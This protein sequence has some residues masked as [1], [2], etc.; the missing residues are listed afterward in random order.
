MSDIYFEYGSFK[1]PAGE[2]YPRRIEL[3]PQH[4]PQGFRWAS[5]YR[6]VV[7]GNFCSDIGTPLTPATVATRVSELEAAYVGDYNDFGFRFV[8]TNV[9]TPHYIETNAA[10]NLSGNKVISASW[11]YMTPA[12]FANTRTFEIQ[13]EALILQAFSN[14]VEFQET[15][16]EIG[17]GGPDW[18][19]RARYQGY[20]VREDI[21]QYTPVELVQKGTV[22]GISSHPQPPAPWWPA[23]EHGPSRVI[24]RH[25]PKVFG[26]PSNARAVLYTTEYK[27]HFRRAVPTNYTPGIWYP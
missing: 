21:T 26:H 7:G 11:D 18:T 14:I 15:V 20:P 9:K 10:G 23:D 12:E 13:L 8:G 24:V 16:A 6:M 27:Y 1:H 22:T 5:L 25:T 2:V 4:T 3:I 19:Y 17:T